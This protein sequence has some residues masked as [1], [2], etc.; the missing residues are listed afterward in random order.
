MKA[1]TCV[2]IM[3]TACPTK[4][5]MLMHQSNPTAPRTEKGS[6]KGRCRFKSAKKLFK[7][8]F[9]RHASAKPNL[10]AIRFDGST[11]GKQL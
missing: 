2:Q 7:A 1:K 5:Y 6:Y 3:H 9:R 11:A 8:Q 4:I 10:I